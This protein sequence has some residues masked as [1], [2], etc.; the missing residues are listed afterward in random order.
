[1]SALHRSGWLLFLASAVL[2]TWSGARAGDWLVVVAS[3]VFGAACVLFLIP[4]GD[5][6]G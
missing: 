1:M 5:P 4:D 6:G 3:V 2:F